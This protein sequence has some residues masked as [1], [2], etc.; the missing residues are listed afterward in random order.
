MKAKNKKKL[1]IS[2]IK[3]DLINA[4][5]V[6]SLNE[7]GLRA[8]DYFLHLS[9]TIFKLMGFEDNEETETIYE[10][11]IEL[12]KRA[13]FVDISQSN[14]PMEDLAVQIYTEIKSRKPTD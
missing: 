9:D 1:I 6:N 12:S 10:R 5:L 2:L 7:I 4:K 3:D 8:D 11:Y 13:L 14:E